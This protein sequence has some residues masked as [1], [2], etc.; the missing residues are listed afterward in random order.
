[1]LHKHRS[2]YI[3]SGLVSCVCE[4]VHFFK[5]KKRKRERESRRRSTSSTAVYDYYMVVVVARV[6]AGVWC[7]SPVPV[8]GMYIN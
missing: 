8:N 4:C 7:C 5:G 6:V 2:D 3:F 1:M